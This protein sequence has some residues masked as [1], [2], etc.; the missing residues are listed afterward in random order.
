MFFY[1]EFRN[2]AMA[3]VDRVLHAENYKEKV[4]YDLDYLLET[5]QSHHIISPN[6]CNK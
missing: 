2:R 1:I 5:E 6:G 4:I 3:T